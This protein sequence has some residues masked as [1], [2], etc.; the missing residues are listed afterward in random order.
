MGGNGG[1]CWG[2]LLFDF[3]FQIA[4]RQCLIDIDMKE[5]EISREE[6]PNGVRHFKWKRGGWRKFRI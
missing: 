6:A 1:E 4:H 2:R 5:I 3:G